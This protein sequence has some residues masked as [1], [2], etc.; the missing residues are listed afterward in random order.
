MEGY[1]GIVTVLKPP[2]MTSNNA[3]YDVR[4]LFG[5][6][7]VGHLGTLDPG[8]AGVLPVCVGRA[9]RLFDYL[10]NKEKTYIAEIAFGIATDTQ[11]SYGKV[12]ET[13]PNCRVTREMLEDV[14]P[15]FVGRQKQTAPAYS[16]L[17]VDGRKMYD[18]ARAG[19][20][21]PEKIR[22][23]TIHGLRLMEQTGD[24]RYLIEVRCSRGTYI[25]TLAFD[26]GAALGVPAYLAFLLRTASGS[27]T[28]DTAYS[29]QELEQRR[30]NGTL[31]E[32]LMS[33]EEALK[34]YPA[35]SLPEN[36][37]IPTMNALESVCR[38][39]DGIVR[40]YANGFLGLGEVRDNRVRLTVHLY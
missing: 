7:R 20:A 3:V 17:K 32:T 23:I 40:V 4:R 19:E 1:E 33:C 39:P 9:A 18:L 27:F 31:S 24:N 28:L 36:R 30:E 12:T 21:V 37:R 25:R 11:D 26:I 13:D 10:V 38:A 8:A 29:V 6:K 35:V 5:V 16:A 2:G 15:K 34:A 22:E 14:L